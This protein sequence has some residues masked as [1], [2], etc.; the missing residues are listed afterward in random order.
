MGASLL[1]AIGQSAWIASSAEEYLSIAAGLAADRPALAA[2]RAG[3]REQMRASPLMDGVAF[4][5][6]LEGLYRGAW[7]AW[8]DE[9]SP[10]PPG[11][12]R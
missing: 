8:C 10:S 3:L 5:R 2:W 4:T 12:A 7:Q 9:A 6:R 1:G 11:S